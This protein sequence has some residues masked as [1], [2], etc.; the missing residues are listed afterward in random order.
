M[1]V[2]RLTRSYVIFLGLV[3]MGCSQRKLGKY[4]NLSKD[5]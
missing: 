5:M 2:M 3:Q 1:T 4:W